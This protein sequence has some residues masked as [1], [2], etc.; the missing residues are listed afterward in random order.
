MSQICDI[1]FDFFNELIDQ[2]KISV[3]FVQYL[4]HFTRCL[5]V[6]WHPRFLPSLSR[7]SRWRAAALC[8][9]WGE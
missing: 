7:S 9:P 4:I 6:D 3:H 8:P 5:N 2:S 1:V